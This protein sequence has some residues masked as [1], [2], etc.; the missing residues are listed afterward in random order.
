MKRTPLRKIS[1][2]KSKQIEEE[3]EVRK[4]LWGRCGGVCEMCGHNGYPFGL[5]PHEKVFRSHGGRMSLSNSQ[6]L[7]QDCHSLKHGIQIK[8]V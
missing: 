2:K 1:A 5:H 7:C 4:A 6:M 3:V 8:E